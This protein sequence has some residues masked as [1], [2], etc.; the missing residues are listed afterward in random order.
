MQRK[1]LTTHTRRIVTDQELGDEELLHDNI[2]IRGKEMKE[3]NIIFSYY[4][5]IDTLS[6]PV[7]QEIALECNWPISKY[8]KKRKSSAEKVSNAEKEKI[9]EILTRKKNEFDRN[10]ELLITSTRVD[11]ISKR[12]Q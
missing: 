4:A 11:R 12:H 7:I 5:L 9:I 3:N 2:P 10:F 8:H 1:R 6:I